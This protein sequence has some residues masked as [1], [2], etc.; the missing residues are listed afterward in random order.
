MMTI[1]RYDW[2]KGAGGDSSRF[3]LPLL[4]FSFFFYQTSVLLAGSDTPRLADE[5]MRLALEHW[6]LEGTG[7][8]HPASQRGDMTSIVHELSV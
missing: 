8:I 2:W 6:N 1:W 5:R 3:F 4:G 7:M